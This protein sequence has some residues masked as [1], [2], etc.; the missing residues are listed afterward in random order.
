MCSVVF[1][2]SLAVKLVNNSDHSSSMNDSY[3][4]EYFKVSLQ[5]VYVLVARK[6]NEI[7]PFTVTKNN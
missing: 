6:E 5:P 3:S 1:S 2:V 4:L 7:F